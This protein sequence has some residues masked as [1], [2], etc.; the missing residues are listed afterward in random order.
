MK[1]ESSGALSNSPSSKLYEDAIARTEPSVLNDSDV[2][3]AGYLP[4]TSTEAVIHQNFI[5]VICLKHGGI[6][7]YNA[8][9]RH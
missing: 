2:I 9:A 3:L 8:S 4:N 1:T 5:V 7:T 6:K